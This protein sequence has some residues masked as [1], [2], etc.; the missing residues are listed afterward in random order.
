MSGTAVRRC[1]VA[2]AAHRPG[3]RRRRER[4]D[5][6][7][8]HAA[9][10]AQVRDAALPRRS[11]GASRWWWAARPICRSC[12]QAA[13]RPHQYRGDAAIRTLSMRRRAGDARASPRRSMRRAAMRCGAASTRSCVVGGAD[14]YAQTMAMADR[15][16]ITRVKLQPAGD[17]S[18]RRS[19][20]SVWREVERTDHAA[21]PGRR[22][23]LFDSRLRADAASVDTPKSLPDTDFNA[24][25]RGAASIARR[26]VTDRFLPY[27]RAQIGDSPAILAGIEEVFDA[28]E[29]SGRWALGIRRWKWWRR[30]WRRGPWGQGP[31]QSGGGSTPPDLEDC[32]GAA[33]TS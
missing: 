23:R 17:T 14:I 8:R 10:A 20:R 29:Q 31:Q 9:V 30:R 15:L 4:R 18:F 27:N 26:V 21:G 19:I 7:G 6:A 16:V 3:R 24:V 2:A 12:A 13:A 22:G 25:R 1:V 11:P 33:R 32:C 28:L 5:R